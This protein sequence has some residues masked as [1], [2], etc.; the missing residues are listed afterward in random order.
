MITDNERFK[1]EVKE[2]VDNRIVSWSLLRWLNEQ[3]VKVRSWFID[4][5]ILFTLGKENKL[6]YSVIYFI[7]RKELHEILDSSKKI[8]KEMILDLVDKLKNW[9]SSHK[10]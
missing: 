9:K 7:F 2:I 8:T 3:E 1:K 4:L 6:L 5:I 10:K